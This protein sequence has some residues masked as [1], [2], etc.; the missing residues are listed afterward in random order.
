MIFLESL[1][2]K[3]NLF[4]TITRCTFNFKIRIGVGSQGPDQEGDG[5]RQKQ[6]HPAALVTREHRRRGLEN[7]LWGGGGRGTQKARFF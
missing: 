6:V 1:T 2:H 7:G 5:E 3:N 4:M